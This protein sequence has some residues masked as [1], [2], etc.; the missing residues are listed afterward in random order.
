L[1]ERKSG[2][3]HYDVYTSVQGVR[4]RY[5]SINQPAEDASGELVGEEFEELL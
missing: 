4:A 1:L 5:F 2:D 3:R